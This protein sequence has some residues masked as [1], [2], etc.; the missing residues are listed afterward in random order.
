[1][2][3]EFETEAVGETASTFREFIKFFRDLIVILLIVILIR[4]FV[5]T[6]FRINGTSMEESYHENEY[7]LVDK[8]SYL[9]FPDTYG[10]K[11][12][13]GSFESE[14]YGLL[15]KIPLRI[16]DPKRG[17]VVVLTPHVDKNREYYIKRIIAIP[18]DTIRITDGYVYIKTATAS[19][20]VQISEPYLSASNSG[21]TYMGTD[22]QETQFTLGPLQYWVMGDNRQNSSD[23]RSCFRGQGACLGKD[24]TAHF[25]KRSDIVGRALINFGYFHIFMDKTWSL[26]LQN[27]GWVSKPR[28]FSHPYH[29]DYP[30][31]NQ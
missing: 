6:P 25:I 4:V 17:D 16:G 9:N 18:G 24:Y 28:L 3:T 19:G 7:I 13:D 23:S 26:D 22:E 30:E 29:A 11:T 27:I 10:T 20:F 2:S 21:H 1:M 31:L 14:A 5:I 12:Q 8:L 15:G